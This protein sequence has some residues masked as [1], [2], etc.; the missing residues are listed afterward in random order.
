[1]EDFLDELTT[2]IKIRIGEFTNSLRSPLNYVACALAEQDSGSVGNNVQFPIED[3]PKGFN[4]KRTTFLRG[5][6]EPHI[7]LIEEYQ[8]YS[9]WSCLKFLRDLSNFYKHRGLIV[10]HRKT[11]YIEWIRAESESLTPRFAVE[12][13]VWRDTRG[14]SQ[15]QPHLPFKITLPDGTPIMQVLGEIQR[16]V[17]IVLRDFEPLI[18]S[19]DDP[20]PKETK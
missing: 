10:V 8:P 12:M 14:V 16:S 5:I 11:H 9:G 17:A 4:R 3:D 1:L 15:V 7:E 18:L 13:D 2:K 6:S 19:S 20:R